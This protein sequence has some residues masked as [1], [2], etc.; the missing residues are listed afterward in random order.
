[1]AS[2]GNVQGRSDCRMP[3]P[4]HTWK[5]KKETMLNIITM[6]GR[7]TRDPELRKTQSG[8]SVAGFT[9]ACDDSRKGPNG[10]KQTVFI[11]ISIFGAQAEIVTKFCR[12]GYLL[13]ISGRLT[14]RKY[15]NKQNVE[16]VSTEII[17]NTIE[18]MEP[19]ANNADAQGNNVAATSPQPVKSSDLNN[20][21]INDDDLPF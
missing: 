19:K 17:A 8:T 1:M 5:G 3:S 13:G 15:T 11:P 18:L 12:K 9:L 14:Q 4:I 7:L 10:E 16:V 2:S 21:E 20:V 6:V